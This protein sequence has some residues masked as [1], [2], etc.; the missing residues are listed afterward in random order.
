MTE[1][2]IYHL[3]FEIYHLKSRHLFFAFHTPRICASLSAE[4]PARSRACL[5]AG[6]FRN[7]SKVAAAVSATGRNVIPFASAFLLLRLLNPPSSPFG[8]THTGMSCQ[9]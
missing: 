1:F 9:G 7:H 2:S 5:A 3:S 8:A 4:I 6:C